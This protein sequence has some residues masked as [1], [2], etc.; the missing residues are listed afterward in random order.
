MHREIHSD[1]IS[2]FPQASFLILFCM[3]AQYLRKWAWLG[4]ATVQGGG[5]LL[6]EEGARQVEELADRTGKLRI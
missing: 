5:I 6:N 3:S 1:L 4:V 2:Y